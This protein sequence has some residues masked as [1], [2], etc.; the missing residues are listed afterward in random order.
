MTHHRTALAVSSVLVGLLVAISGCSLTA[1]PDIGTI[2]QSDGFGDD[3]DGQVYTEDDEDLGIVE[4]Y[5]VEPD[6]SLTPAGDDTTESVWDMFVKIVTP[7]SPA[8]SS[9]TSASE[10]RSP[11]TPSRTFHRLTTRSSG[12]SS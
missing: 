1:F 8:A 10:T 2:D 3:G 6:A 9:E 12:R 11:A 7:R 5:A 4:V